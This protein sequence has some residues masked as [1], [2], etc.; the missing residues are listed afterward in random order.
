MLRIKTEFIDF[1]QEV[2]RQISSLIR[3]LM[4]G[5]IEGFKALFK[6]TQQ[7]SNKYGLRK[8]LITWTEHNSIFGID[9]A[10]GRIKWQIKYKIEHPQL[11]LISIFE[12]KRKTA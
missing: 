6:P 11:S 1:I 4:I 2:K 7:F 10:D 9:S 5:N 3:N 12:I 8:T